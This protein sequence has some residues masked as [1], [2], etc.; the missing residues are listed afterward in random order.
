[1]TF[2]ETLIRLIEQIFGIGVLIY[3]K[4]D[5]MGKMKSVLLVFGCMSFVS[6][7]MFLN[8]SSD[9]E[10][11]DSAVL[12]A[13]IQNLNVVRLKVTGN[14]QLTGSIK[15]ANVQARTIPTSGTNAG[16]CDG[17]AGTLLAK[18]FT[19][20]GSVD[21]NDG[22]TYS[23][24]MEK[25]AD[26]TICIVIT[27]TPE[28]S[29]YSPFQKRLIPWRPRVTSNGQTNS[30]R[31]TSLLVLS[32]ANSV[33]VREFKAS[34]NINP[35]TNMATAKFSSAMRQRTQLQIRSK[36][37]EIQSSVLSPTDIEKLVSNSNEAI[38]QIFFKGSTVKVDPSKMNFSDPTAPGYDPGLAVQVRYCYG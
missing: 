22:G 34:G 30:V 6:C 15:N 18:G 28:S 24:S 9:S 20:Y 31:V 3:F 17:E 33:S 27:P 7:S 21:K 26:S 32:D 2:F 13:R 35:L 14:A 25:P 19:S 12:A 10:A 4:G 37:G 16:K 5:F 11:G 36:S 38:G 8:K 23:L 1:M 29:A